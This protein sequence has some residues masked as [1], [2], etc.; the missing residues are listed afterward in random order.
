MARVDYEEISRCNISDTRSVVISSCSAGG[1]TIAQQLG[2][3]EGTTGECTNVFMKGAFHVNDL[4]G[5][6][7]FRDLLNLCITKIES[8]QLTDVNEWDK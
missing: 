8:G 1:Y 4:Q 3:K 5:L 6:Y 2:V 7:A